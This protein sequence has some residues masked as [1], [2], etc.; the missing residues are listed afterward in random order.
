MCALIHHQLVV[1][2]IVRSHF[3]DEYSSTYA[4]I[5]GNLSGVLVSRHEVIDHPR[6]LPPNSV[7]ILG[8]HLGR[9]PP[10]PLSAELSEWADGADEGLVIFCLGH[11]LHLRLDR[12]ALS[13]LAAAFSRW[14]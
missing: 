7:Y 6:P 8:S 9:E 11:T 12:R 3:P 1:D 2:P 5:S 4:E 14:I 10:E 13:S